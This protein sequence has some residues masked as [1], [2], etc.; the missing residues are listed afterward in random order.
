VHGV[1]LGYSPPDVRVQGLD[2]FE[3]DIVLTVYLDSSLETTPEWVFN[4]KIS[5][6]KTFYLGFEIPIFL[7]RRI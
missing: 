1:D 7:E 6:P 4:L 5:A 2:L 3:L